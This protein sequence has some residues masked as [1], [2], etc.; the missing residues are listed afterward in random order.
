MLINQQEL[1]TMCLN[2]K[3]FE[4]LKTQVR[5]QLK[6]ITNPIR[7][8]CT[9]RTFESLF[10]DLTKECSEE[11]AEFCRENGLGLDGKHFDY[12][13]LSVALDYDCDLLYEDN[14]FD[15]KT[16]KPLGYREAQKELGKG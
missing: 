16:G 2:K 7:R 8:Y 3:A 10:T 9:S 4:D 12:E 14:D 11:G 5:N 1:E 15:S 6:G 13:G